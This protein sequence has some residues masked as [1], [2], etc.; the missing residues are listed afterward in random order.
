MMLWAFA[1]GPGKAWAGLRLS[2]SALARTPAQASQ[3]T[4]GSSCGRMERRKDRAGKAI[5]KCCLLFH[6]KIKELAEMLAP[7]ALRKS[8]CSQPSFSIVV[9]CTQPTVTCL[10]GTGLG[11]RLCSS[12]SHAMLKKHAGE[13]VLRKARRS[14]L[15]EYQQ[16]APSSAA[17]RQSNIPQKLQHGSIGA[18]D[19]MIARTRLWACTT[20][21]VLPALPGLCMAAA[22]R[23]ST[24]NVSE[25]SPQ[26]ISNIAWA[27]ALSALSDSDGQRTALDRA[28]ILG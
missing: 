13:A 4:G 6:L 15:D 28:M 14:L 9:L 3:S 25:L 1:A 16:F 21:R 18:R 24:A 5:C 10:S 27:L 19:R 20:L 22:T 17:D 2:R 12:S 7:E 26:S 23:T 11:L 8:G